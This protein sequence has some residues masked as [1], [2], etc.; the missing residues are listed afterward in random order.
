MRFATALKVAVVTYSFKMAISPTDKNPAIMQE[1]HGTRCLITDPAADRYLERAKKK[2]QYTI[3]QDSYSRW[4]GGA[5]GFDLFV[6]RVH[7]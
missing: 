1:L 7:E 4:C 3:P 5:N 2:A 6:E